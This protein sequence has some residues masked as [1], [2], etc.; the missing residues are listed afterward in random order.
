MKHKYKSHKSIRKLKNKKHQ[1]LCS[2]KG[3]IRRCYSRNKNTRKKNSLSESRREIY[4]E[5]YIEE[6]EEYTDIRIEKTVIKKDPKSPLIRKRSIFRH[7]FFFKICPCP[8][9]K[10]RGMPNSSVYFTFL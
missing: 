5:N 3:N 6:N 1:I 4:L 10:N 8:F 7:P 2:L 9:F